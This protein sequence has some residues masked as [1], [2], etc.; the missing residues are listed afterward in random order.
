VW[1]EPR[2]WDT[3]VDQLED[4]GCE[5]IE[6]QTDDWEGSTREEIMEDCVSV[7]QLLT[8]T[9]FVPH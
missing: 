4:A 9:D 5:V 2:T 8:D 6:E 7:H 3:F 1:G